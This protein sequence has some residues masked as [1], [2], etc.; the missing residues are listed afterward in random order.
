MNGIFGFPG[1]FLYECIYL[2]VHQ[3]WKIVDYVLKTKYYIYQPEISKFSL[4][5]FFKS[6]TRSCQ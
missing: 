3:S 6:K 1:L 2:W 4:V 5:Y